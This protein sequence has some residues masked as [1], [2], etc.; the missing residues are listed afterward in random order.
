MLDELLTLEM[1]GDGFDDTS[2]YFDCNNDYPVAYD[3]DNDGYNEQLCY[4]SGTDYWGEPTDV[5]IMVDTDIDG[6]MDTV[7]ERHADV[8][9]NL[10]AHGEYHDYNQDGQPDMIKMLADTTGDG[11]FDTVTTVHTDNT[12][13]PVL[14]T[15]DINIDRTGNQSS[16]VTVHTEIIDS[17]GNGQPDMVEV[18]VKD[19]YG[20]SFSY[21][22]PYDDYLAMTGNEDYLAYTTAGFPDYMTGAKQFDPSASD[23]D[24]VSGDPV[25]DMERWEYQG[26]T[27]RCALYAQKFAIEEALGREVSIEEI[28]SVAEDNGWFNESSGGG[29]APLNMNKLLEYYGVEHEMSFNNDINALEEALKEGK[30]VIVGLDSSQIWYNSPNNIF[31]PDTHANHAVQVIGI[32]HTDPENPMVILND[33]GTPDG[34]GELVALEVFE[35]AWNAGDSQMIVCLA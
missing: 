32:D 27:N 23:C 34:C 15:I 10:I 33:S 35:N 11:M 22:M 4:F 5:M 2:L 28:V 29:T 19:I 17:T 18:S 8:Y 9:G 26:D 25:S 1:S 13:S 12:D 14:Q 7:I 24:A 16:D 30:N 6:N 20:Q 3:L 31:S 21:S